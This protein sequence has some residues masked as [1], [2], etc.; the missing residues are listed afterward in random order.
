MMNNIPVI[1]MMSCLLLF[2]YG[3]TAFALEPMP[4]TNDAVNRLNEAI[5][6]IGAPSESCGTD[7]SKVKA[8]IETYKKIFSLAGFDYERSIMRVINDIQFDRYRASTAYFTLYGLARDLLRLHV[9]AD[10]HPKTYLGKDC[11]ELLIEL[12][13]IIRSNLKKYGGC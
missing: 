2:T 1:I 9:R 7:S 13:N 11:A 6:R 4:L 12:R 10:I 8:Y 3:D 5:D